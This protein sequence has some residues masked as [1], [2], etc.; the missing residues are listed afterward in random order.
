MWRHVHLNNIHG[1]PRTSGDDPA[2]RLVLVFVASSRCSRCSQPH[3]DLPYPQG[4]YKIQLEKNSPV[5][6][7]QPTEFTQLDHERRFKK[8]LAALLTG[9]SIYSLA[10]LTFTHWIAAGCTFKTYLFKEQNHAPVFQRS[11]HS[12]QCCWKLKDPLQLQLCSS[13]SCLAASQPWPWWD[14]KSMPEYLFPRCP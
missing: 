11:L 10:V 2:V 9:T 8:V 14:P 3:P 13:T 6:M 1:G 4:E 5:C 12:W 7:F